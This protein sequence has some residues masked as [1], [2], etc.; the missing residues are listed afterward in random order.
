[1]SR[2]QKRETALVDTS[3]RTIWTVARKKDSMYALVLDYY[4]YNTY[5]FG[6]FIHMSIVYIHRPG[7]E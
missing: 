6:S 4:T 7:N 2:N 1:M 3:P 5:E